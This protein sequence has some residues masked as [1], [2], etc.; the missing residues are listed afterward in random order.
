VQVFPNLADELI[1]YGV[2]L[3]WLLAGFFERAVMRISGQGVTRVRSDRGSFALIYAAVFLSI[4]VA[5]YFAYAGVGILPEWVFGLGITLMALGI[6]V[7]EWAVVTLRGYFSFIVRVRDDHRVVD[8]GPYRFVRHPAYA[9]S[10]TTLLGLGLALRT[11]VGVLALAALFSG[12]FGYR[13]RVEEKAMV[14][15]LGE[16]YTDY[17]KRTKRIIP[18]LY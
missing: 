11:W 3:A 4:L 1:F 6:G 12:A 14:K 9:G 7:R 10:M 17:I 16:P 2:Y 8:W 15:E 13:I 18:Y 5:Y